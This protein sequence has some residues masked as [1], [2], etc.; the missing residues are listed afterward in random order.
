MNA[1]GSQGMM[2]LYTIHVAWSAGRSHEAMNH[3]VYN[4]LKS[5]DNVDG[6]D[7]IFTVLPGLHGPQY[8]FIYAMKCPF[9]SVTSLLAFSP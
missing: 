2:S 7:S 5:G 6:G 3:T 4:F 9:L 8:S 1:C